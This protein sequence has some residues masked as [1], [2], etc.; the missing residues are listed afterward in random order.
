[1]EVDRLKSKKSV[2]L[3]SV[4][5]MVFFMP[6]LS[7]AHGIAGKRI[8]PSTFLV[9]DPAMADEAA[10]LINNIKQDGQ[11]ST[12]ADIAWSKT[13]VPHFGLQFDEPY[14]H[15]GSSDGQPGA[16]G[17][18]NFDV[19]AKWQ[20]LTNA[21]HELMMSLGTDVEIGGTGAGQVSDSFSTISP[22]WYFGKGMGDLP[23]SLG[24]LKPVAIT[25]VIGPSFPTSGI[26]T[27]W[28]W[29]LTFQYSLMYLED[30][31]K[32]IG[33]G[34]P[35]NRMVFVTEFPMQTNLN[36]NQDGLTTGSVNPGMVWIGRYLELGAAAEIPV[37]AA[38]GNSVGVL[39]LVN[40]FLDDVFP[41]SIGKPIWQ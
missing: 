37:N 7:W 34:A 22:T 2:A 19:G 17:W 1:M 26:G 32:Y 18:E 13:I 4:L 8:F 40:V 31:V 20:F 5:L 41:H 10:I 3:L 38:S 21:R 16:N 39:G 27:V 33:L 24:L 30:Y 9:D 23:D 11:V 29:G 36:G 6:T 28:N 15:I 12:E 35:F 14:Q 25:G